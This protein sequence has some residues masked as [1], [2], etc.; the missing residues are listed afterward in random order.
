M[1]TWSIA[2]LSISK[3]SPRESL[4]ESLTGSLRANSQSDASGAYLAEEVVIREQN[5]SQSR[6]KSHVRL[7]T[8]LECWIKQTAGLGQH[9]ALLAKRNV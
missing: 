3:G 9:G 6:D 7:K 8:M 2:S 1:E 5:R 4:T